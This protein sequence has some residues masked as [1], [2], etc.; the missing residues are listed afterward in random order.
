MN[1]AT[2]AAIGYGILAAVGGILG[3]TQARSQTSLISG[4]I[5][6]ILLIVGGIAHQQNLSWGLP[7][8]V[9]ITILLIIVFVIR[10]IKTR[11]FM[12][13]GL[14][15]VAGIVALLGLTA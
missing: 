9:G 13:A 6:G 7:L 15:V 14:M 3:Y 1:L 12:P 10:F 5:S 4:L 8:S 11:K 2:L